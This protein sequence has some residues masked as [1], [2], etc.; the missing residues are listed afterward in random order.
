LPQSSGVTNNVVGNGSRYAGSELQSFSGG[1][2]LETRED[3]A[4]RFPEGER[5]PLKI[6]SLRFNFREVSVVKTPSRPKS[7]TSSF[8]GTEVTLRY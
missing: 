5:D 6:Q 1:L 2:G 4:D 8:V 7:I 3:F